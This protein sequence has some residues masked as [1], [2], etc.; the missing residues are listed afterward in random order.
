MFI[1]KFCK[2]FKQKRIANLY[3][4]IF[5]ILV[6]K[7]SINYSNAN[8]LEKTQETFMLLFDKHMYRIKRKCRQIDCPRMQQLLNIKNI[9]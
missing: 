8:E 3:K 2:D 7:N 9:Y 6:K 5:C 1:S 4:I